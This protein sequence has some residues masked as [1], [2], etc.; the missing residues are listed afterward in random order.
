MLIGITPGGF[1]FFESKLAGGRKSD[2]Q[3]RVESGLVNYLE[4]GDIVWD[5]KGFPEI[6][7][8][9]VENQK[10]YFL[11]LQYL[12]LKELREKSLK[13]SNPM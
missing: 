5:D 13:E 4:N 8:K 6:K 10:Q 7:K 11:K 12:K 3:I 2:A 9:I 1:I